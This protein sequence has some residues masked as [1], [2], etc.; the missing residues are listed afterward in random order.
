[1][2]LPQAR[3]AAQQ[4]AAARFETAHDLVAWMGAVQA[5]D[6]GAAKW[7]LGLRLAGGGVTDD[8]IERAVADGS[9]LRTHALRYTWQ[10]VTPEDLRWMVA[11]VAPRLVSRSAARE[12]EL[13]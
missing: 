11:L 3:L 9:I 10:L 1:M 2:K 5:Q 8:A 12:R 4:L 6:Y 7:A 13:G